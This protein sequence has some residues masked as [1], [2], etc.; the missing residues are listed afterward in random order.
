MPAV[1]LLA[2][3]TVIPAVQPSTTAA[4]SNAAAP[5]A[6]ANPVISA[7]VSLVVL[8]EDAD[9][10]TNLCTQLHANLETVRNAVRIHEAAKP[11]DDAT[12]EAKDAWQKKREDLANTLGA[13][14]A[15]IDKFGRDTLPAFQR[16][17]ADAKADLETART[18]V[19]ATPEDN[20]R[21]AD[22]VSRIDLALVAILKLQGPP[23]ARTT[24]AGSPAKPSAP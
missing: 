22:A 1:L 24:P 8:A 2:C 14:L 6:P 12:A 3:V 13:A 18:K 23:P 4:A 9:Q 10:L 16:K 19:R 11:G 7:V 5:T 17:V 15:S 20:K 21:A